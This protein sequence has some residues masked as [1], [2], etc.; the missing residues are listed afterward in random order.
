[1]RA[2]ITKLFPDCANS[3]G[4]AAYFDFDTTAYKNGVHTIEWSVKDDAG[5]TTG[6]G[7]RYFTIRN[8]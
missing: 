1:P 3:K 4:A 6:I 7:S 8:P 2:D 5:N